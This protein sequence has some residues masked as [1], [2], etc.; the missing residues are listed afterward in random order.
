MIVPGN[1]FEYLEARAALDAIDDGELD[2]ETSARDARRPCPACPGIACAG[3][4]DEAELFAE[5][6]SAAPYAGS[7]TRPSAISSISSPPAAMR[8]RPM[9]ASG[10]SSRKPWP[11]AP[12]KAGI[13]QQHRMNA[14]VI[15]E[16]P[17]MDVR[18]KGGRSSALSRKASPRPCHPAT[19][20]SSPGSALRSSGSR[21]PTSSST[22]RRIGADRHLRRAA[23][24]DVDPPR[25]PRPAD[26]RRSQR[27][28]P[29][30]RRRREWLEVQSER[31]LLP[32]PTSCWSRPS[33]TKAAT[34]WS[35]TASKA[36]TPTSRSACC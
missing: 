18:F 8:S 1:R 12:G 16:Q 5:I 35:P 25:Q 10:G 3:P 33:P 24:V 4:F 20:S 6:R 28:A 30:S 7:R 11:L 29:L 2:P 19:I 13:A 31:S 23:H 34:T 15:V 22:P 32:E 21:T 14:G 17:L 26:A 9:T 27:L 36:G